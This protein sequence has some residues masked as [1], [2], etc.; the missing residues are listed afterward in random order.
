ME[1]RKIKALIKSGQSLSEP[2]D[3]EG[4]MLATIHLPSAWTT[5]GS[6]TVQVAHTDGGTYQDLY[7]D[8]GVEVAITGPASP[9]GKSIA[10]TTNAVALASAQFIKLRS[11][12]SGTPVAQ[13]ADRT[14][15][16]SVKR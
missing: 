1:T 14:I 2:I 8:T 4:Y 11:G 3:L 9:A 15:Y 7:D 12:T 13:G 5:A 10:I 16:L 6:L